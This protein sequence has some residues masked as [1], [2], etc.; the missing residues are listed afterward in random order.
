MKQCPIHMNISGIMDCLNRHTL[1]GGNDGKYWYAW[2]TA[3]RKGS[4]CL[5]C[6]RCERAC[7][8][9]IDIVNQ[10]ERAVELFEA[11]VR[12]GYMGAVALG[13]KE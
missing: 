7:P 8:Q 9:H 6:H 4:E 13:K 1:Y 12:D 3:T 11:N 2:E 5:K 10:I